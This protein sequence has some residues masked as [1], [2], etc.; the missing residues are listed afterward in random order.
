MGVVVEEARDDAFADDYYAQ[1]VEVFANQG[2]TPTYNVARVRLLIKH[3]LPTGCLLLLR[4]RDPERRCI[5]TGIFLGNEPECPTSGETPVGN[6]IARSA[7]TNAALARHALLEET[8]R[9]SGTTSAAAEST[10][11]NTAGRN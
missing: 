8:R 1:L 10:S 4:A 11:E 7:P 3:L 2:L 9:S 5:A 6:G